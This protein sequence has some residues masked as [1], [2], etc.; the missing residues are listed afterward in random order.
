M[1]VEVSRNFDDVP[2]AG[3]PVIRQ[4]HVVLVVVQRQADLKG[5]ETGLALN[6]FLH[7][8]CK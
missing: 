4:V 5:K 8:N 6:I 1:N 2:G 3:L 7:K